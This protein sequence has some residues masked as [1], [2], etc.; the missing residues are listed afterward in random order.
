MAERKL[1]GYWRSSAAYRVRIALHL[2]GLEYT[3]CPVHLVKEG[4]E[5]HSAAYHQLNPSELVPTLIDDG[6]T[7]SQSLAIIEYLDDVYPQM[8]LIPR[9]GHKKYQVLSLA[10]DIAMDIHPIN[11]LRVLQYLSN[12]LAVNDE[13]KAEWYRHWVQ[14][15]FA[16]F[17]EKLNTRAGAFCVGDELSLADVCLVPQIYNAERF[18][19][20]MTP[21]PQIQRITQSLRAIPGFI[22]AEPENQPDAQ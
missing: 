20:D 17:E 14:V 5:Q 9:S 8:P 10:H 2:K 18:S 7:L 12:E 16:A 1:Y 22:K 19:V 11:N 15:G 21:Y 3:H 4:G 6:V 13:Q